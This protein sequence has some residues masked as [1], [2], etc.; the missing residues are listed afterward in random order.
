MMNGSEDVAKQGVVNVG[1]QRM[2]VSARNRGDGQETIL[3]TTKF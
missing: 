1:E 2:A 3:Y